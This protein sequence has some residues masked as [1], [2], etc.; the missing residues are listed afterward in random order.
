MHKE[1]HYRGS[2]VV[3][4]WLAEQGLTLAVCHSDCG[5]AYTRSAFRP[6]QADNPFR[7]RAHGRLGCRRHAARR[8]HTSPQLQQ[9]RRVR[10]VSQLAASCWTGTP[11]IVG[12][13]VDGAVAIDIDTDRPSRRFVGAS[14]ARPVLLFAR[15]RCG[16]SAVQDHA[17]GH[18]HGHVRVPNSCKPDSRNATTFYFCPTP[19]LS[20]AV[21]TAAP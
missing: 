21:S 1:S 7:V 15:G 13:L 6:C 4:W 11:A 8:C 3:R 19:M 14:M 10:W 9:S 18:R 17:G 12:K 5:R 16:R 20:G 2:D